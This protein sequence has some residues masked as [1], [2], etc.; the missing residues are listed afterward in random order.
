MKNGPMTLFYQTVSHPVHEEYN[1][2]E[3][4]IG[5]AGRLIYM[6]ILIIPYPADY[7]DGV[8]LI[9]A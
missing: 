9:I 1:Q 2:Y 4:N 6:N 7:R 5:V 8:R 3:R